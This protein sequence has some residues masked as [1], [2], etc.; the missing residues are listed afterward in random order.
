MPSL[1][2]LQD[3][4]APSEESLRSLSRDLA[5]AVQGEVRF[6]A[7]DRML[8]ATDASIYQMEPLGVVVPASPE[9]AEA[10]VR[11]CA[12]R[13][14]PMLPR[15]GGTSLAGQCVNRA[16]VIDL[17]AHARAVRSVDV[18][19][20]SC[21]VDAG[22]TIDALNRHL[23]PTG[24]LFAPDPSTVRQATIGGCIG[25][26]AAGTRSI[27]YGRTA[28]NL[29]GVDAILPTG[30]RVWFD[31]GAATR[32]PVA[33]R[34][35]AEVVDIVKRHERL[36]RERFPTTLRRNAGYALDMILQQMDRPGHPFETVNLAHLLCGSEG[37]LAFTA[38]ARLLLHPVPRARGLAVLGF[39]SLE[40]AIEM[41]EPLLAV[42]PGAVELLDDMVLSTAR[43]NIEYRS[44][45]DL[46]PTPAGGELRAVL[47]IEVLEDTDEAALQTEQH[48]RRI[49]G[50]TAMSFYTEPRA[51]LQALK[52]RQ[53]GEPLLHAIPGE[54]KPLGF[55]EDNAVPV[56][57]LVEFVREFKRIV[58]DHGTQA[59]FYAH[60][61]VG[62]LHVRPLL[63]LRLAEDREAVLDIAERVAELARSLGGVMSGE[64]GDGRARGPL[65]ER[66]FGPELMAAFREVKAVFD[67]D[68]LL[69]PGNI[70]APDPLP[71]IVER[72]R[73][74]PEGQDLPTPG[75]E[76]Y[77]DYSD[78]DGFGHAV[79][80]CN[81][82]G[83]CRKT[84]GGTMCPSYIAT[85]D[86]RHSTRG[87]GNA[88]R[89]AITGQLGGGAPSW[90]DPDTIETLDL[91]LSCKACKSECPSNVDIARLKAEYTAQ[92]FRADGGAPLRARLF[93]GVRTLNRL[94]SLTPRLANATNRLPPVRAII[95]RVMRLA[96][97]RS[98]PAFEKPL[99]RRLGPPPPADPAMRTLLLYGDC[100][101]TY[102]ETAIGVDTVRLLGAFG[103]RVVFIDAGCCAR[104]M[105]ST[106]LLDQARREIERAVPKLRRAMEQENSAGLIVIEPS[107]LSAIRDDWL[108]LRSGASLDDRRWLAERAWLPEQFLAERWDEHPRRPRFDAPEGRV[109]LH[110]HCHQKAL[111]GIDSSAALLRYAFGADRVEALDTGCCGMAGSFGYDRDKYDLSMRIG[112]LGIF[113][114]VREA[115]SA[116]AV[117][118][119]GTSCRH[120]ILDGTGRH[121]L[122]PVSYLASR[123]ERPGS[124]SGA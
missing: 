53:A 55:V 24:L 16:V 124:R 54:R 80:R 122:H 56:G 52:L 81:G 7:H 76:T 107:C 35:T 97:D 87:R 93:G 6:G 77:F 109:L 94:G 39:D 85:L 95:N 27:R 44:Y 84:S 92:R 70:V 30:L 102:N 67:P 72:T 32:D 123:L 10:A 51:M 68:G 88:L 45:V 113:P 82:A 26:N 99:G 13:H 34:L 66:F 83:V 89:L 65:L 61:S 63:S 43:Q 12:G 114:K 121:A 3:H 38:G 15:G 42:N 57:R 31:E 71:S 74:R 37:T 33:K 73:I 75:V 21:E 110:G 11:F 108:E 59:A 117:L 105:I 18:P 118:A 48:I 50:D 14:L 17:S 120:Q 8:Y 28:E 58:A 4:P 79:E 5:N 25:N 91:C 23:A 62:V 9:D 41:V 115:S 46:M 29:L 100:F 60:A 2:V 20:R 104:A 78:Q 103:Y 90:N 69:N 101:S 112:E 64:H 19:G 96:P 111:W 116:D 119:P 1:P 36:I 86:E 40:A 98:L 22:I 106:G 49:A 47:Y